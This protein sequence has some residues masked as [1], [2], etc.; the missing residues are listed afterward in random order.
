M[1][2]K[3]NREI[4]VEYDDTLK[5]YYVIWDLAVAGLGKTKQSAL[6]DLR[7]AAHFGI[8]TTIDFQL[9]ILETEKEA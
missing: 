5:S 9:K 3:E 1:E 2:T 7:R 6:N 8:D 4:I